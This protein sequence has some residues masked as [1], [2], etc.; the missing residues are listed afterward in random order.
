MNSRIPSQRSDTS[1]SRGGGGA[2]LKGL[3]DKKRTRDARDSCSQVTSTVNP[4][5]SF[6]DADLP[7]NRIRDNEPLVIAA[8][9]NGF[10]VCRILIDQGSS[11]DIMFWSLFDNMGLGSKDLIPHK[12]SLISFTGDTII[13]KGYVDLKVCFGKKPSA[14]TILVKFII[15]NC[16]SAYN[17]IIGRPTLKSLGAIVSTVH[18][19]M[20]Y[21]G[22]NRAVVMVH[23]KSSDARR[24]N[25]EN[26]KITKAPSTIPVKTEEK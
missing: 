4:I 24:C 6:L 22:E 7:E 23:R 11:V 5:L 21:P 26:L 2:S 15:V 19:A 13:P 25:Q 3:D 17:A 1:H 10:E 20:K 16:P 14:K 18:L 12:G 9:L 8:N